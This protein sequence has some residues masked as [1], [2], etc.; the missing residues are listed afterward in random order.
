MKCPICHAEL[1][2]TAAE[3]GC[4]RCALAQA[5]DASPAQAPAGA[6]DSLEGYELLH[7]LGRG[8][9]G[10]VWLARERQLDRMVALKLIAAGA[11]PVLGQ[12]LLREGRA[13][14]RLSHANIVAVH[15]LGGSGSSTFL[16]MDFMEGGNL[17]EHL[18]GLTLAPAPAAELTA[19]LADALAH[20]H[21]AGI[22]H[23]DLKPSNVLLDADG[24]P[25]LADFG[26]AAP[27]DGQG[28]LTSAGQFAGTPAYLPPELLGGSDRASPRSDVYG[29]GA[30]LYF[31]LTGRPPF[32]GNSPAAIL[33]QLAQAEPVAPHFLQPGIPRDLETICLKCLEKTPERRYASAA[34]LEEDLRRFLR[35]EPIAARPV[36]WVGKLVRWS[37]RKPGAATASGLAVLILLL[38]AIG[39]PLVAL[40][41]ERSRQA[42]AEAAGT[43]NDMLGFLQNDLLAQASPENEPDRDVKLRTVLDRAEKNIGARLANRPV[44]EAS[45]RETLG[46]TYLALGEFSVAQRHLLAA[47]DLRRRLLGAEAPETL[48]TESALVA[49]LLGLGKYPEAEEQARALARIDERVLGAE[50]TDTL[51]VKTHLA[52]ALWR[53]G[54]YA[55]AETLLQ[56]LLA[57]RTRGSGPEARETI[58]VMDNLAAVY[59]E[60]GKFPQAE[61]LYRQTL[62]INRRVLGPENPETLSL[63][64]DLVVVYNRAGKLPEGEAMAKQVLEIS[65]RV[66]G[67]EHPATLESA[68]NLA[69]IY[70]D[71]GRSADAAELMAQVL[72]IHRRVSGPEHPETLIAMTNMA[73]LFRDLHR[74]QEAEE[75][76]IQTVAIRRRVSGP[77]HPYTAAALAVLAAI[78]KAQ[79]KLPEAEKTAREALD[80]RTRG[81]GAGHVDTLWSATY[82]GDL[83]LRER[84]FEEAG[85]LLRQTLDL[86][87]QMKLEPWLIALTESRL[88]DAMMNTGRMAEAEPL[89]LEGYAGLKRDTDRIPVFLRVE[90]GSAGDRLVRL[91]AGW[92]KPEQAES[93]KKTLAGK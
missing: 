64:S 81:L 72:E 2:G 86:S 33:S 46:E 20:A 10:V 44:A 85:V 56:A 15:A 75:L 54:K 9:M 45:I 69:G 13:A 25:R 43:A 87:V 50:H 70:R 18:R 57:A 84:K 5:L 61:T 27:L 24:E 88:G 78:Y 90:V 79:G 35:G 32:V 36:G 22:L 60:Q 6:A 14:A 42:A 51:T 29:L 66:L 21:A 16:A 83:L 73:A 71:E 39:G 80:A 11:D 31:C 77:D 17:E 82:L 76:L 30:I 63:M 8:G 74:Y 62:E 49:V 19:K 55:E 93:W 38:F 65:R 59:A 28:D 58:L 89:L 52:T 48:K 1:S 26:L 67:A 7:E 41:L 91:Y 53:S 12:R 4:P 23:R 34:A 40:R 47:R 68:N 92:G 3:T 37:R